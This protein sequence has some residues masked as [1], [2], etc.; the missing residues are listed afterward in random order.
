MGV[1]DFTIDVKLDNLHIT[2]EYNRAKLAYGS[3]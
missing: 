1:K 2:F 3:L